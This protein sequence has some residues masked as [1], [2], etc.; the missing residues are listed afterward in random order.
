MTKLKLFLSIIAFLI[1]PTLWSS[2][3]PKPLVQPSTPSLQQQ[4]QPPGR[5]L[6]QQERLALKKV[7]FR[8]GLDLLKREKVPFDPEE[9]LKP[10][11]KQ[12]LKPILEQMPDLRLAKQGDN[13][14]KGVQ[15]AHTL[16]LPDNIQLT[17]DTVILVRR[18]VF[19]GQN[20]FIKGPHDLQIFTLEE[21]ELVANAGNSK[22]AQ[23]KFIKADFRGDR[24]AEPAGRSGGQITIDLSGVGRDDCLKNQAIAA[25]KLR[26]GRRDSHHAFAALLQSCNHNGSNGG[27]GSTG[28]SGT[29]GSNGTIASNGAHG[30][31][32]TNVHGGNAGNGGGGGPG[33]AGGTGGTGQTGGSG[34][35][36]YIEPGV[37]QS[38]NATANGGT[39]GLGGAGGI[40]GVGGYGAAGGDGGNGAVCTPCNGGLAS[41]GGTGGNGGNGGTGGAAGNGGTGGTGGTGGYIEVAYPPGYTGSV[42]ATANGGDGGPGGVAGVSGAGGTYGVNGNGG[43]ANNGYSCSTTGNPG[44]DGNSGNI[45]GNGANGSDGGSGATG[46]GGDV[47]IHPQEGGGEGCT[48]ETCPGHCFEGICTPTPV[49][50]DVL[51]NGFDLTNPAGGV[52]FD[53]NADGTAEHLAWTAAAGDD[54][55]LALD[56]NNDG[57]ITDGTELFGDFTPQPAPP[58]GELKNGFLA[59]AE[60]DKTANGGNGDG[61]MSQSDSIFNSLRLWQDTNHNGVS[62]PSELRTLSE[63][64]I[65]TIECKYK[66]SKR[67]DQHG[68]WFIYRAKVKGVQGARV[69]RWAWDVILMRLPE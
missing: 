64:G 53:L 42:N 63:L 54:A 37:N 17:G 62:E 10:R 68:N 22:A 1:L 34:G 44:Q 2:D 41:N 51:G 26:S 50:I 56:R 69:E 30:N 19:L 27:T 25:A 11:W 12:A 66:E 28:S 45:G 55:W 33:T 65:A 8:K 23:A 60:Y 47:Y 61:L 59:L 4:K 67:T 57:A 46:T 43:D 20:V 35:S 31:C 32:E 29:A 14:L 9:L 18:L 40:G 6:T 52:S 49:L 21:T 7:A 13:K 39:G 15:M 16:Y 48:P 24:N 36:C 38:V 3:E 58:P 5:S